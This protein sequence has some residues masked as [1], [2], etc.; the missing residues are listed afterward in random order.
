MTELATLGLDAPRHNGNVQVYST[1]GQIPRDP[2]ESL[3]LD[4]PDTFIPE[5]ANPGGLPQ[6][7]VDTRVPRGWPF[8]CCTKHPEGDVEWYGFEPCFVCVPV[9]RNGDE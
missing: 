6:H 5:F 9:T 1:P 7:A 8:N 4:D 2:Y 3:G